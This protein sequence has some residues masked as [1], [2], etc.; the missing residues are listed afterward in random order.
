MMRVAVGIKV[1][2][3]VEAEEAAGRTGQPAPKIVV[4]FVEHIDD[5]DQIE[6]VVSDELSG[7]GFGG[8]EFEILN[9]LG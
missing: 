1:A 7:M 8:L 4:I 3:S 9:I 2:D 5:L 6:A